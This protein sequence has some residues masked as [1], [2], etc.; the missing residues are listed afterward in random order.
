MRHVNWFFSFLFLNLF[1]SVTI[2]SCSHGIDLVT[3]SSTTEKNKFGSWARTFWEVSGKTDTYIQ[4]LIKRSKNNIGTLTTFWS[5]V[6]WTRQSEHET[7]HIL[8]PDIKSND[9]CFFYFLILLWD[10]ALGTIVC[11]RL[12][13]LTL[14]LRKERLES[15]GTFASLLEVL[16]I[17]FIFF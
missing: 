17:F 10:A 3:A 8:D 4:M 7:T 13:L 2:I 1:D 5:T 12:P 9:Y 11:L 6:A 15:N 16:L 14:E